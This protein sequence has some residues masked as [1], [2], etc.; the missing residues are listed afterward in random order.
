MSPV[1]KKTSKK[2]KPARAPS[3][4]SAAPEKKKEAKKA[5][6]ARPPVPKA[7]AKTPTAKE[8]ASAPPPSRPPAAKAPTVKKVSRT[9][10]KKRPPTK[11]SGAQPSSHLLPARS[12][13]TGEPSA[14]LGLKWQCFSCH[15]KFYDLNKPEPLCPRCG[16]NQHQRPKVEPR[17]RASAPEP[18]RRRPP[19]P[20][21]PLLEEEDDEAI[22]ADD[23]DIDLGLEGVEEAGEEFIGPEGDDDLDEE[24]EEEEI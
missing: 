20:M 9:P 5:A 6:A 14:K 21:A 4:K 12:P 10:T 13:L 7:S 11:G 24:E 15:A 19:R 18:P 23:D 8:K 17:S 22:V 16:A 2:A 3:R 1:R